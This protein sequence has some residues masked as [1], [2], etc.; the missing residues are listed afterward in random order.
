MKIVL[1]LLFIGRAK[2]FKR[3]VASA[4]AG[5]IVINNGNAFAYANATDQEIDKKGL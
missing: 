2:S 4:D 5:S 1:A 3:S